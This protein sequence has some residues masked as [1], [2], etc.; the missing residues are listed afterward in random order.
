MAYILGFTCAD[1]CIYHRTLSW[2]LSNKFSS[3]KDLL[4]RFNMVLN[5]NYPIENRNKSVRLRI[6][7]SEMISDLKKLGVIPNKIKILSFPTVPERY[8][9]H[10]IRGFLDG[11]G[12]IITMIRKH[13]GKEICVGFSNGS[14]DFMNGLVYNLGNT[15]RIRNFNLRERKKFTKKGDVAITYQ[16][17]FYSDNAKRI[18]EF[19]YD[20]L[21][22]ENLFLKRKFKK[23]LT[24][25][26]FYEKT[27][28]L[29][30]LEKDG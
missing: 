7:S 18:I 28:K 2:E 9:G 29:N 10:F 21:N 13:G 25:R 14:R 8:L 23:Q 5:S 19:L 12:W 17:E 16:L 30:I 4:K 3:D 22:K 11:D 20:G 6:F 27:K 1:G 26:Q 15:L 24:A